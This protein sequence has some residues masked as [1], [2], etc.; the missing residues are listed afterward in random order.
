VI[1]GLRFPSA[2]DRDLRL[3]AYAMCGRRLTMGFLS[4]L[5]STSLALPGFS[6][7]EIGLGFRWHWTKTTQTWRRVYIYTPPGYDTDLDRRYPVLY[8]QHGGGKD[9]RG[10]TTQGRMS[11]IMDNA[12][13]AG[14][15]CAAQIRSAREVLTTKR[16]I[17][18]N[19]R[20]KYA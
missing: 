13:A 5:R 2:F 17:C 15:V 10:W 16:T 12:I 3:R 7:V 20:T 6:P 14:A 4:V 1:H 9:E 19:G 11:F 8:L 18:W